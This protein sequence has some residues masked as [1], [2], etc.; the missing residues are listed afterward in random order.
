MVRRGLRARCPMCGT[1]GLFR[2]WLTIAER[3]P[4]CGLKLEQDDAAF[5]GSMSLNYGFAGI[6]FFVFLTV[7]LI[8]TLPDVEV[9]PLTVASMV[10]IAASLVVFFRISKTTWSA[11]SLALRDRADIDIVPPAEE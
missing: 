4:T 9:L 3:C 2:G 11:L 8:L 1:G 10:V 7:W 6:V 5:L